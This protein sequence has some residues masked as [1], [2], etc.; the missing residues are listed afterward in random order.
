M[1]RLLRIEYPGALYH[2]MNRGVARQN[3]FNNEDH[4]SCFF[5]LLEEVHR[6]FQIEIRA[7]CLMRNNYHLL[8]RSLVND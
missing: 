6:R 4:Y 7:Y 3:I 5:Q 2:V 8:V 1:S